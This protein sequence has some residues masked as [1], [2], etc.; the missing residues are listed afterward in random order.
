MGLKYLAVAHEQKGDTA[1]A[2]EH[3]EKS[4]KMKERIGDQHG[5]AISYFNLGILYSKTADRDQARQ[6]FE[7][8]KALYEMLGLSRDAQD[9]AQALQTL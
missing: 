5:A 1:G 4:L 7:K 3:Y 8:A 6:H 9:A 2:L